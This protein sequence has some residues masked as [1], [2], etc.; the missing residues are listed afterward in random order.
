MFFKKKHA[1]KTNIENDDL[2][3]LDFDDESFNKLKNISTEIVVEDGNTITFNPTKKVCGFEI[4]QNEKLWRS[5]DFSK[6]IYFEYND[7]VSAELYQNN[8]TIYKSGAGKALAG[9]ALFGLAGAVVGKAAGSKQYAIV[10]TLFIQITTNIDK[11]PVVKVNLLPAFQKVESGSVAHRAAI[12][13]ASEIIA[14]VNYM[15]NISQNTADNS[16]DTITTISSADE[17]KKYYDLYQTGIITNDEFEQKK[18]SL[19]GL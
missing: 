6:H 11:Y 10:D 7:I 19:L 14:L 2:K 4:D 16:V 17:I 18:Q 5:T 9:A 8:S 15:K 13:N 1:V 3:P 12:A